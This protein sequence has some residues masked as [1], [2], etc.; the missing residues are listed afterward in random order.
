MRYWPWPGGWG[1]GT[2]VCVVLSA[3]E[4]EQLA[5]IVAD[6]NRPRKHRERAPHRAC[7]G[8]SALGARGGAKHRRQPADGVAVATTLRRER[9]RGFI[10][11]QDPQARQG[12]DR[13]GNHGAGGGIDPRFRESRLCAAP[14]HQ[15]TH[16]TGRAMAKAIGMSLGSRQRI[17]WA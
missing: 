4:R 15:A 6:Y 1:H 17:C 12:A 9:G 3:A 8:R 16:W 13:G 10:A 14:P 11:R 2:T 7:L 5:A